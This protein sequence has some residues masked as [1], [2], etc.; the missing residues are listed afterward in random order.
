MKEVIK[1]KATVEI[2][3]FD[4]TVFFTLSVDDGDRSLLTEDDDLAIKKVLPA[5]SDA[6]DLWPVVEELDGEAVVREKLWEVIDANDDE[7]DDEP[8]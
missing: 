6:A 8:A 5:Y 2:G 4:F 3:G 1:R 7:E